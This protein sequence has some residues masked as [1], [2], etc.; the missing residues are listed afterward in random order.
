VNP[1]ALRYLLLLL[2]L[3]ALIAVGGSPSRALAQATRP[4]AASRGAA[5][6]AAV[7]LKQG[8]TLDEVRQL[9]GRPRRTAL[10]G[11]GNTEGIG[12]RTLRWTYVWTSPSASSSAERTLNVDFT[13]KTAEQWNVSG[14]NWSAY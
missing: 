2:L 3:A 13:A 4:A 9:L 11:N 1:A 10:T 14:W 8:M 5:E 6:G 12:A 7:D